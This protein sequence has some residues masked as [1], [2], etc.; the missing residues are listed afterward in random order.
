M[1]IFLKWK[2]WCVKNIAKNNHTQVRS[3]RGCL[4]TAEP[5][6]TKKTVGQPWRL[7]T[8]CYPFLFLYLFVMEIIF[9]EMLT[10]HRYLWQP[11]ENLLN[12]FIITTQRQNI[13]QYPSSSLLW[14]KLHTQMDYGVRNKRGGRKQEHQKK[15]LRS[16][17]I[18]FTDF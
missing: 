17:V 14:I 3:F 4:L 10:E 5:F 7:I 8:Y 2:K 15:V 9:S 11:T 18:I 16:L 1:V 12:S 6:L 13:A